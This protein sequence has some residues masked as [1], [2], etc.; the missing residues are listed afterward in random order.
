MNRYV[1]R[2]GV[3]QLIAAE[4]GDSEDMCCN[5]PGVFVGVAGTDLMRRSKRSLGRRDRQIVILGLHSNLRQWP[6]VANPS[7]TDPKPQANK[8]PGTEMTTG[9]AKLITLF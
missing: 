3:T 6:I 2:P 8:R 9:M 4:G 5:I 1:E 7:R